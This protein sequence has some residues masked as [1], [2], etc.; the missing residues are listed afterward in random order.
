MMT[1]DDPP[2]ITPRSAGSPTLLAG[3]N[4]GP[5]RTLSDPAPV[6]AA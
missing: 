4:A 3:N 1:F 2:M 5:S 6:V